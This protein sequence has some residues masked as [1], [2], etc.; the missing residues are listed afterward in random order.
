MSGNIRTPRV[1]GHR[2]PPPPETP[3]QYQAEIARLQTLL[4]ECRHRSHQHCLRANVQHSRAELWKLR[5]QKLRD[6]K[7]SRTLRRLAET[8]IPQDDRGG[9]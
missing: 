9:V 2:K 1:G 3:A 5:Y 4:K 6:E 8:A 7:P